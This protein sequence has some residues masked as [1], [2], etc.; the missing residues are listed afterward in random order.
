MV[1]WHALTFNELTNHQL[2]D[3]LKLR[4]NV[5]VVEQNCA[6]PE[7]DEK[8]RHPQTRHLMGFQDNTLVACARLLAQGVSYPSVSIGRVATTEAFRGKG[9]GKQLMREAI[10]HCEALWPNCDIEIGAQEY[11]KGF[12]NSFG[13]E[14][15]SPM[16]LE[17]DIPHIDM[18]R[19]GAN[20]P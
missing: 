2:F 17:D 12:Y 4:V 18:K 1:S 14:A 20:K 5:F 19:L 8:D 16:Y 10:K 6:Y 11:L 9:A 15:T 3:L 13:F 7:L